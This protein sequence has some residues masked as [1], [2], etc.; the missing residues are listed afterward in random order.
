MVR[1]VMNESRTRQR[2][3]SPNEREIKFDTVNRSPKLTREVKFDTDPKIETNFNPNSPNT[4]RT[5]NYSKTTSSTRNASPL[6][7]EI[8]ELGTTDL[9]PVLKDVPIA[10]DSLPQPGTK[11]TTTVKT[12]PNSNIKSFFCCTV[13]IFPD[14]NVLL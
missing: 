3:Q 4:M 12:N 13:F 1:K 8:V 2:S 9:P 6:R 5:Y 10:S 11:V 14:K 7:T